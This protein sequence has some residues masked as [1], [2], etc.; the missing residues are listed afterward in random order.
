MEA[1]CSGSAVKTFIVTYKK[2]TNYIYCREQG[3]VKTEIIHL[4]KFNE[5][6]DISVHVARLYVAT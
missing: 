5:P 3:T 2:N 6:V 4:Q 1:S